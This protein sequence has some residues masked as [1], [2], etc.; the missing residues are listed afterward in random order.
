MV[1][2][3]I[4]ASDVV[5]FAVVVVLVVVVDFDVD[6]VEYIVDSPRYSLLIPRT[7]VQ[8]QWQCG[9]GTVITFKFKLRHRTGALLP[10]FVL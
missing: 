7:N 3:V 2:G 6:H 9:T 10:T 1:V 5:A 4:V 8:W